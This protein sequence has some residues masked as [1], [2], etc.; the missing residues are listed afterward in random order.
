M[1][2]AYLMSGVPSL[3]TGPAVCDDRGAGCF[4]CDEATGL[5]LNCLF[6][7]KRMSGVPSRFTGDATLPDE[8]TFAWGPLFTL[9]RMS[10]VPSFLT[11]QEYGV[12]SLRDDFEVFWEDACVTAS[13]FTLNLLSGVPSFFN[14]CP[15]W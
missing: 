4:V 9:K 11:G 15:P 1:F 3:L 13:L 5:L 2:I 6:T 7:E 14:G 12:L 10:G 8:G